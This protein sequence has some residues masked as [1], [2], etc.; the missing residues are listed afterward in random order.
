M[1]GKG[2]ERRGDQ[3]VYTITPGFHFVRALPLG[4]GNEIFQVLFLLS[5]EMSSFRFKSRNLIKWRIN[6]IIITEKIYF[7]E[8]SLV[9]TRG[10]SWSLVFTRVHS[11]VLLETIILDS[12]SCLFHV[13]LL[14]SPSES[15][16]TPYTTLISC[17][18]KIALSV[19]IYP[20]LR[21]KN[22]E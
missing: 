14:F 3:R 7:S 19:E 10:L 8:F 18:W 20:F 6:D 5:P 4:K 21:S 9:V 22:S 17:S 2:Q 12:L 16:G 1:T 15:F 11:C 13:F